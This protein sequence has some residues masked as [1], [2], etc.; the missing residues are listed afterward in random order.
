MKVESRQ[1]SS[2]PPRALVLT[3]R[4]AAQLARVLEAGLERLLV[5]EDLSA[6]V[7]TILREQEQQTRPYERT[8]PKP[9]SC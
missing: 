8:R 4:G 5:M 7:S 2:P 1:L 3:G 9:D 6:A